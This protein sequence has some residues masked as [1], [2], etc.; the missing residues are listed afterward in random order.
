[1]RSMATPGRSVIPA[2]EAFIITVGVSHRHREHD[3]GRALRALE[4]KGF[5]AGPT[6]DD[7]ILAL[8]RQVELT[9]Q[10]EQN[11]D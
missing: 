11:D 3:C 10:L 4:A 8:A 6:S 2:E 7:A 1:M 9:Q 5:T